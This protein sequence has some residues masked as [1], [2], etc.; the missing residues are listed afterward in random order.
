[1]LAESKVSLKMPATQAT[2]AESTTSLKIP[3]TTT[4][5]SVGVLGTAGGG[6]IRHQPRYIVS[7]RNRISNEH[8]SKC[9]SMLK[10]EHKR[11]AKR[12]KAP[13]CPCDMAYINELNVV[14]KEPS[15]KS[16]GYLTKF[17]EDIEE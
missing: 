16:A 13:S 11:S 5:T 9:A 2:L 6:K 4:S 7:T 14:K 3:A 12:V 8:Q 17:A 1:M 10:E 15:P